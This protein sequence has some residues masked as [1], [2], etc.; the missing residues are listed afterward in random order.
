MS[1]ER[2]EPGREAERAN[3]NDSP[4]GSPPSEPRRSVEVTGRLGML[5]GASLLLGAVPIPILPT[6]VL[7]QL[8]GAVAYDALGRHGLSMVSAARDV[9]AEPDTSDRTRQVLRKG[10]EFASRRLLSRFGPFSALSAAA[11]AFELYSLGHLLE[12]YATHVRPS[13]TVRVQEAEARIVRQ[14][15]DKAV[16][17]AFSPS[18]EP[19]KLLLP[20][21]PEDLRDELTR[22]LDTLVLTVATLP[23]YLERRLDA[24]F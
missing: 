11:R 9:L 14:T 8:R 18:T 6:R 16:L 4:H 17:R 10:V 19:R 3:A 22:W 7:R 15:I 5:T 13:G 12:R 20:S 23:S 2:A 21:A 24:A 1:D